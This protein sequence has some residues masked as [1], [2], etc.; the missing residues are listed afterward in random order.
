MYCIWTGRAMLLWT[1]RIHLMVAS[2]D[3]L[4]ASKWEKSSNW[5]VS[6]CDWRL[7]ASLYYL[8]IL[9]NWMMFGKCKGIW[10]SVKKYVH[11]SDLV[12]IFGTHYKFDFCKPFF[13]K[14]EKICT[15]IY[16][17]QKIV[18]TRSSKTFIGQKY[19]GIHIFHLN[20][21]NKP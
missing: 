18:M 6:S 1:T 15:A 17:P 10:R 11:C 21:Q 13:K 8:N 9:R 19:V 12:N 4:W 20:N 5:A 14:L 7:L 3:W 2:V 16:R